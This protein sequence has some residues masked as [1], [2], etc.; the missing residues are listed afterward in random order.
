VGK[1]LIPE[2]YGDELSAS[3][4][5]CF[6]PRERASDIRL[7]GPQR[8][9]GGYGEEETVCLPKIE[10]PAVRTIAWSLYWLSHPGL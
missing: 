1:F 9:S 2:V 7:S 8:W 6:I 3:R 5:G 4:A 10:A